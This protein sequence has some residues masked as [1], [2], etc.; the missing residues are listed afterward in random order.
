M[1]A[2]TRLRYHMTPTPR[3]IAATP[4]PTRSVTISGLAIASPTDTLAPRSRGRRLLIRFG[5]IICSYFVPRF[6]TSSVNSKALHSLSFGTH[7]CE[8]ACSSVDWMVPH[9]SVCT[10]SYSHASDAMSYAS[11]QWL[12]HSLVSGMESLELLSKASKPQSFFTTSSAPLSA[13]TMRVPVV[14]AHAGAHTR[15]EAVV[16]LIRSSMPAEHSEHSVHAPSARM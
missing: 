8:K 12:L 5:S 6:A 15:F 11:Q 16:H 13:S 7:T 2:L 4:K 9:A 1:V 14:T 10:P 3:T